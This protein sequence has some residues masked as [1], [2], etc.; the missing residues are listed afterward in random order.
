MYRDSAKKKK[1]ET[2][3]IL[4]FRSPFNTGKLLFEFNGLQYHF[5]ANP[6]SVPYR[7]HKKYKPCQLKT[8]LP[9]VLDIRLLYYPKALYCSIASSSR[10]LENILEVGKVLEWTPEEASL[11]SRIDLSLLQR[12]ETQNHQIF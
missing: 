8:T 5:E 12:Q 6:A 4:T 11:Y 1:N 10:A 3:K 7:P 2:Q 9:T